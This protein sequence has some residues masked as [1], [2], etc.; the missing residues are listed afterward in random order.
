MPSGEQIAFQPA[1]AEMLAQH[2]HHTAIDAQV[3]IDF[4]DFRHPGFAGCLVHVLQAV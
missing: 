2:L 3:G 4:L 1:L